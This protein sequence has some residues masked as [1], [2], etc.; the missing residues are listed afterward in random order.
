MRTFL[1][2]GRHLMATYSKN[3][4]QQANVEVDIN[5]LSNGI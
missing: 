4:A 2:N 5:M 3:Q 1:T